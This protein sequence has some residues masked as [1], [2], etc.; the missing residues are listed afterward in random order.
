MGK[1]KLETNIKRNLISAQKDGS[2]SYERLAT[3]QKAFRDAALSF[4]QSSLRHR[5]ERLRKRGGPEVSQIIEV[6]NISARPFDKTLIN[7]SVKGTLCY[8]GFP[9]KFAYSTGACVRNVLLSC[10]GGYNVLLC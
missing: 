6:S 7:R 9:K 3:F 5:W 8:G 10:C 4:L 1:R 2:F